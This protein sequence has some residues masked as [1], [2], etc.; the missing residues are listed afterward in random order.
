M[1]KCIESFE[2]VVLGLL[3]HVMPSIFFGRI[4]RSE[5]LVHNSYFFQNSRSME[6]IRHNILI[7]LWYSMNRNNWYSTKR[8]NWYSTKQNNLKQVLSL[9]FL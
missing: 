6:I 2:K 9:K 7:R 1:D 3:A 8:N 4:L 5:T